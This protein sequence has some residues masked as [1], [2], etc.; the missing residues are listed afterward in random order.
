MESGKVATFS[1]TARDLENRT[2]SLFSS[3]WRGSVGF[4]LAQRYFS[5]VGC[6][7]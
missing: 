1:L 5:W 4:V 7:C 2:M 3:N 6:C